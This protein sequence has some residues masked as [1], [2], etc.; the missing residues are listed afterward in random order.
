MANVFTLL[1]FFLI[2]YALLLL[3]IN[4]DPGLSLTYCTARSNWVA[5]TFEWGKLC[6]KVN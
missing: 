3:N 4:D 6:Y 2:S 1:N 5:C